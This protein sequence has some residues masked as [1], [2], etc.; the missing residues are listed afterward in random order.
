MEMANASG[1]ALKFQFEKIPFVGGAR[2]YAEKGIFPGGAFEN[3]KH[4]EPQ[5]HFVD[6]VDETNQML[7]FDPQTS[8]GLLLGVPQDQLDS[9][10]ARAHEMGQAVWAVGTVEKGTG[11]E[12]Y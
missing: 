12:V 10:L 7:M 1:V 9:F 2:T 6:S 4:F 8:G 3:R 11:I 5:V